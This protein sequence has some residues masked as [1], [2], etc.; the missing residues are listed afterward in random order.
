MP[1]NTYETPHATSDHPAVLPTLLGDFT[2]PHHPLIK[3]D[4]RLTDVF[5]HRF[6]LETSSG[7]RRLADLGPKGLELA[8]LK[9]EDAISL[10]GEEHPS[11]IKVTKIARNGGEFI[12]IPRPT[13]P[14][15]K[16]EGIGADPVRAIEAVKAAGAAILGDAV[17]HPKHFEVLGQKATGYFEYH[18]ESDGHIR[19]ERPVGIGDRK[20]SSVIQR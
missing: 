15:H 20:W 9:L 17:R 2:L 16:L 6:V 18:V 8:Q 1:V 12:E 11:E 4:G 19:K 10:E 5:A 3:I 7:E 14:G 13:K